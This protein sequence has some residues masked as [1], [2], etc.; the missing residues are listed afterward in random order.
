VAAETKAAAE[1]K[2][3]AKADANAKAEEAKQKAEEEASATKKLADQE[4][5]RKEALAGLAEATHDF[6]REKAGVLCGVWGG[7]G[8]SFR[9]HTLVA[10]GLIHQ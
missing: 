3:K 2:A 7:V 9:P 10:S 5:A 1:E 8:S 6:P 4:A